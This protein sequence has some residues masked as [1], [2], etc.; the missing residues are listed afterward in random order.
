MFSRS[1]TLSILLLLP[2]LLWGQVLYEI[3][4][5]GLPSKSYIFAE[6]KWVETSYLDSVPELLKA[7]GH[8]RQV[9]VECFLNTVDATSDMQQAALLPDTMSYDKLYNRD[10]YQLVNQALFNRLS[11]NL[12]Q[13][14]RLRPS[15]IS[16]LFLSTLYKDEL[17]YDE[18]RSMENF[19]PFI[20][21]EQGNDIKS[22]DNLQQTMQQMFYREPLEYQAGELYNMIVYWD[23]EVD[24]V[25]RLTEAYR[26]GELADMSYIVRGPENK[27]TMSFSDY[28][29]WS[30]RWE[31]WVRELGEY[32]RQCSSFIVL[33]ARYLG[34]DKGLLQAL[35]AAGYKV[36]PVKQHK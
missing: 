11:M 24:V 5:N 27:S 34:S 25:R 22:L 30:S 35:R 12:E 17:G 26:K 6:C 7:Y 4:G 21:I 16:D 2:A 20:A 28:Q 15:A 36:K 14:G 33:D 3:S 8:C 1:K 13:L 9:I 23:R 32:M 10:E 18:R 31:R 19:F 29:A